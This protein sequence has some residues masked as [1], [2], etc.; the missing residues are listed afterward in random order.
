MA[1]VGEIRMFPYSFN[2]WG[3]LPC[4]G[5]QVPIQQ[6]AALYSVIGAQY[7]GDGATNFNLPNLT[8]TIPVGAGSYP[9]G[10]NLGSAAVTLSPNQIAAHS[11]A[12]NG[13]VAPV[14]FMSAEAS[15]DVSMLSCALTS[16]RAITGA[17]STPGPRAPT[18][19]VGADVSYSGSGT[20]GPH[21]NLMPYLEIG[22]FICYE[23]T[24]PGDPC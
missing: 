16:D 14:G 13:Q 10:Q 21:S 6:C 24:L 11:H 23:G 8:G 20:I 12:M 22:Y 5:R 3:W 1:F 18:T 4:D 17:Y 15:T 7:G 9:F 2:I 19:T